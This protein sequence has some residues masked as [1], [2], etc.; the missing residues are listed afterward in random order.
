[1]H[2]FSCL[3]SPSISNL[4]ECLDLVSV[5]SCLHPLLCTVSKRKMTVYQVCYKYFEMSGVN[6]MV[7]TFHKAGQ[8]ASLVR[9]FLLCSAPSVISLM[10]PIHLVPGYKSNLYSPLLSPV[11][12]KPG[13]GRLVA[14]K[15]CYKTARVPL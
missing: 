12:E 8:P 10:L 5:P 14:K 3:Q 6:S 2:S 11:V 1:M 4:R 13:S 9:C 7:I 15:A